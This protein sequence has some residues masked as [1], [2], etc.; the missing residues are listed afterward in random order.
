MAPAKYVLHEMFSNRVNSVGARTSIRPF[1]RPPSPRSFW[2][3]ASRTGTT[4]CG[5]PRGRRGGGRRPPL[6]RGEEEVGQERRR[7]GRRARRRR[8]GERRRWGGGGAAGPPAG[9]ELPAA[10]AAV[11]GILAVDVGSRRPRGRRRP[12]EEE[13]V[14]GCRCRPESTPEGRRG[15]PGGGPPPAPGRRRRR[16]GG[17]GPRGPARPT[18]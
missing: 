6:R 1:D 3:T 8:R 2:R 15:G 16:G 4:S 13:R 10:A 12:T 11:V 14:G 9:A 18:P 7:W 17:R 5:P